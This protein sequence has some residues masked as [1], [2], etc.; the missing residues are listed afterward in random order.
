MGIFIHPS[1][2]FYNYKCLHL[3]LDIFA[4]ALKAHAVHK[5]TSFFLHHIKSCTDNLRIALTRSA[6]VKHKFG[7]AAHM[8]IFSF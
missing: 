7:M 6:T 3:T 4:Y 5:I 1:L 2:L 8:N